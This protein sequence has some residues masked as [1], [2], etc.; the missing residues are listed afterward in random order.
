[1]A[2]REEAVPAIKEVQATLGELREAIRGLSE[3][4]AAALEPLERLPLDDVEESIAAVQAAV[5]DNL[6]IREA[7]PDGSELRIT[8]SRRS[9]RRRVGAVGD[10]P[11]PGGANG[12]D[13]PI[14]QDG[15]VRV[16]GPIPAGST[17]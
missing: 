6:E 1:M 11:W 13:G 12:S 5:E 15:A 7:L 16:A 9:R 2:W 8:G 10:S 17:R 3:R 14:A 4:L